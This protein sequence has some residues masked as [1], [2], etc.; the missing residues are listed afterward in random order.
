MN[1]ELEQLMKNLRLKRMLEIYGE[2]LG[3]A[4]KEDASYTEFLLRLLRRSGRPARSTCWKGASSGPACPNSG[5][6][7]PFPTPNSQV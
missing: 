6:W 4:E 3:S 7:R 1:E 2:Q 5:R